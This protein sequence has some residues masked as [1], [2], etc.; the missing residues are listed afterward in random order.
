M[1]KTKWVLE[2]FGDVHGT[3]SENLEFKQSTRPSLL[4]K[5]FL[6]ALKTMDYVYKI[7]V[8]LSWFYSKYNEKNK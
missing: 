5:C 3:L 6:L 1:K 2:Y 7:I 8:E 4:L